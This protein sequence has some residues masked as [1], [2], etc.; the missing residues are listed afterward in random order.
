MEVKCNFKNDKAKSKENILMFHGTTSFHP[1]AHIFWL[2][3]CFLQTNNFLVPYQN[4][5]KRKTQ[6]FPV[7]RELFVC[8][9]ARPH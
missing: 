8:G 5:I 7:I 1:A 6:K 4:Q 2:K 9:S 3:V